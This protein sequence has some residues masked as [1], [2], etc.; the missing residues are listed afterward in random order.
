MCLK[1]YDPTDRTGV[2]NSL[3]P[4]TSF[5]MHMQAAFLAI[6]GLER[7]SPRC[8]SAGL[9]IPQL[10]ISYVSLMVDRNSAE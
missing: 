5:Y 7:L 6:I 8:V 9:P 3:F 2:H 10:T 4:H 1:G